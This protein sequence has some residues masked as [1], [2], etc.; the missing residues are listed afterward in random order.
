LAA[1]SPSPTW[2]TRALLLLAIASAVLLHFVPSLGIHFRPIPE[3]ILAGRL[4]MLVLPSFRHPD[5][6]QLL[7]MLFWLHD[8]GAPVERALGTR[9]FA[10]LAA[11]L[12]L[13]PNLAQSILVPDIPTGLAPL[14]YGLLAYAWIRSRRDPSFRIAVNPF[15][16]PILL[17]YLAFSLFPNSA[18]L[19]FHAILAS[20]LAAALLAFFPTRR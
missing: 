11:A 6:W 12:V 17:L 14:V 9:A 18:P 1:F 19:P 4:W 13:I 5:L 3:G 16:P 2:I 20:V 10:A 15:T 7:L 8:L